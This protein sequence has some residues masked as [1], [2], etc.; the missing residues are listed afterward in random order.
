MSRLPTSVRFTEEMKGHVALGE[1]DFR[2]GADQGRADGTFLMFH[3]TIEIPDMA[4]FHRDPL[5]GGTCQGW[6]G[7]EVLGGQLPVEHGEFNLFVDQGVPTDKRMR[8]R[9]WFRDGAGHPLTLTGFKVVRDHPGFDVW[10]D[11]STLY[12]RVLRGHVEAADAFPTDLR[13]DVPPPTDGPAADIVAS[14][15][16]TIW[17]RDF[18]RQLTTFRAS[19]GPWRDR[20]GAVADFGAVFVRQ[21]GQVYLGRAK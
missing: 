17:K 5:R 10:T 12:T 11:T 7:C 20:L 15:V 21:L 14:G 4:A 9:L 6:V 2:A 8:Y 16:I 18:L 3:L 13:P 19:G 1:T